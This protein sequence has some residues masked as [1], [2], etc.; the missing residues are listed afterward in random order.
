MG[1]G[2]VVAQRWVLTRRHVE[3]L[4]GAGHEVPWP[5]SE[6]GLRTL[7]PRV[8]LLDTIYKVMPPLFAGL[9][10]DWLAVSVPT[11]LESIDFIR[12]LGRHDRSLID[13]M[14]T[15]TNGIRIG[16]CWLGDQLQNSDILP[17]WLDRFQD[18]ETESGDAQ[19]VLDR[20]EPP[21][22]EAD[23]PPICRAT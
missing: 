11:T 15:Y 22:P 20:D 1:R 9:A 14:V 21:D 23:F 5:L 12:G 19:D 17:M 4:V 3:E 2:G 10:H 13:V 7:L 8:E 18:L 6:S 16:V